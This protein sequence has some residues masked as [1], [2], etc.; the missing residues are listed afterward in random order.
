MR[1]IESQGYAS[2]VCAVPAELHSINHPDWEIC[3]TDLH[4][5]H[6]VGEGEFG[7]VHYGL[8]NGTPVAI[9]V[10]SSCFLLLLLF[11]MRSLICCPFSPRIVL[12]CCAKRHYT[13][14]I[15]SIDQFCLVLQ[16]DCI[17]VYP[18]MRRT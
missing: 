13:C 15:A 12:C 6:V 3:L 18:G 7:V 10:H 16:P 11:C 4:L 1:P 8:W 9:K 2:L 17:Q 14:E 5:G